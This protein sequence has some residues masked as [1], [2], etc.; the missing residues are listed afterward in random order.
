MCGIKSYL[1]KKNCF[2]GN[3]RLLRTSAAARQLALKVG[4]P[5]I[6]IR[7]ISKT[8]VNG[9]KGEVVQLSEKGP[10]VRFGE[11]LVPLQKY[12]FDVYD[13]EVARVLAVRYQYPIK[14]AYALMMHRAQGQTLHK[15]VVDCSG[16]RNPGQ[17]GVAVGRAVSSHGLQV[18]NYN[19][20]SASLKHPQSVYDFYVRQCEQPQEDLSCCTHN[21]DDTPPASECVPA[22]DQP[23]GTETRDRDLSSA[24]EEDLRSAMEEDLRSEVEDLESF[25]GDVQIFFE[26][27]LNLPQNPTDTTNNLKEIITNIKSHPNANFFLDKIWMK[28]K[29]IFPI[30]DVKSAKGGKKSAKLTEATSKLN[31]FVTSD[32]FKSMCTLI[33][34][35][36]IKP[37]E[38][39]VCT[40]AVYGCVDM[41][42]ESCLPQENA[43]KPDVSIT[44]ELPDVVRSKI[45]HICVKTIGERL[46]NAISRNWTNHKRKDEVLNMYKKNKILQKLEISEAEIKATSSDP[47]SLKET[48]ERQGLRRGLRNIT[49]PTNTFFTQLFH[50]VSKYATKKN[51]G[52]HGEDFAIVV[53]S[54]L[55]KDVNM[56]DQW[57]ALFGEFESDISEDLYTCM[58]L[59]I[60]EDTVDHYV[61]IHISDFIKQYRP[62][63]RFKKL[64]LR[65]SIKGKEGKV[66]EGSKTGRK[67][68]G[69]EI[70]ELPT[71]H[72]IYNCGVCREECTDSPKKT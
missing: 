56:L 57:F 19:R 63:E 31:D 58:L 25:P 13:Q 32:R 70:S 54:K 62:N 42:L 26:N 66:R 49:D 38:N 3:H 64:A 48:Q 46:K 22:E 43:A 33:F 35:E 4:C 28:I 65:T 51:L 59:E 72:T 9:L 5:V 69:K 17:I 6:L 50:Q 2:S 20:T 14:L 36:Q 10:V 60:Y 68:K 12:S 11:Q 41:F 15:L 23:E 27:I 1:I 39:L 30:D 37:L 55:Q 67:R 7:N 18:L 40:K 52:T 71:K 45:R 44:V 47:E 34:K 61:K 29:E 21:V 16:V 24:M 8:L 53:H